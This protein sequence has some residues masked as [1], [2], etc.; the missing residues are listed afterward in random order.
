ME[1]RFPNTRRT[2]RTNRNVLRTHKFT[3]HLSNDDE[4]HLPHRSRPRMAIHI[5]GQYRNSYEVRE[6][7]NG[8]TTFR[9]PPTLYPP[10]ASQAGTKRSIPQTRKVRLR[11]KGNRLPRGYRRQWSDTNGSEET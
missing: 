3:C 4:H 2:I 7:Q 1:S 9:T 8:T 10:H 6:R 11:E 5:H